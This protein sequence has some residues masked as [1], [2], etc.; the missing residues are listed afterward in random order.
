MT[1][2]GAVDDAV[3][4]TET[5]LGAVTVAVANAGMNAWGELDELTPRSLR[6]ALATN[7]EGPA[8]LARA[9]L[10]G[11]VERGAG[12]FL[13]VSSD[14]GRRPEAGGAGYVAS[15]FG[16]VG[17]ALSLSQELYATGVGVHRSSPAAWTRNGI[18]R[19]KRRRVSACSIPTTSPTS[20][21]TLATLPASIVVEEL[22]PLPRGLLVDPW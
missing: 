12:K 6:D 11:M 3:A 7:V 16:A 15:K 8:N 18:H 1:D 4:R 2:P 17:F 13:V 21:W 9:V 10:P 5:E 22:M 20:P 19:R 14:N